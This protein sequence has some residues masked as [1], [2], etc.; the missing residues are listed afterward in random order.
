[1]SISCYT[2]I[3]AGDIMTECSETI[4]KCYQVR[5]TRKQKTAFIEFM[6]QQFPDHQITVESGGLTRS[7]NLVVGDIESAKFILAAHY[8]TQPVLPFPNFLTPKNMPIYL[9][10]TLCIFLF[11]FIITLFVM[12]AAKV[13]FQSTPLA[14]ALARITLGLLLIGMLFGP[15]NKHT[16][17]DN[18]SGIITLIEAMH[19]PQI[20]SHAAF[21][22]FDQEELGLFGSAYFAK[23]HKETMKNKLLINFDCVSDGDHLMF[24]FSR[25]AQHYKNQFQEAFVSTQHKHAIH[26]D[27]SNTLY[28]S[29][30]MNFKQSVGVAAFNK[31]KWIGYYMDKIHTP[32]D[33]VFDRDNIDYLV[34]GIKKLFQ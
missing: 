9:L 3:K 33:T 17:N 4:L 11:F 26:T 7:R 16:A 19:D 8:D 31:H 5:K 28:P 12:L 10:Y 30:Q 13:L 27:A 15:A 18:T 6:K 32:K 20:A 34:A 22:F 2:S 23:K 1:M 24:I 21:V 14:S 29:D 25:Q